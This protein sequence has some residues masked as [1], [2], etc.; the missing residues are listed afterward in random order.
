MYIFPHSDK[1]L[2]LESSKSTHTDVAFDFGSNCFLY[3]KAVSQ[4]KST[5]EVKKVSNCLPSP[6]SFHERMLMLCESRNDDWSKTVYSRIKDGFNLE[7]QAA[8][9]HE[10]CRNNFRNKKNISS[11]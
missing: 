4:Y 1:T 9:F 6:A 2:L 5:T 11:P 8:V 3:R 7:N 10:E